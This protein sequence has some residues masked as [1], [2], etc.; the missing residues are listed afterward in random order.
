MPKQTAFI[1]PNFILK[2]QIYTNLRGADD[3]ETL[4][5]ALL[6]SAVLIRCDSNVE[7]DVHSIKLDGKIWSKCYF[8]VKR[9]A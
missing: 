5:F 9:I 7:L 6:F 1:Y 3:P 2:M 4:Y 8:I